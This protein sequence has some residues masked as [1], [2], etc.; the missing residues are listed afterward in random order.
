MKFL[1]SCRGNLTIKISIFLRM[2]GYIMRGNFIMM[3]NVEK[4]CCC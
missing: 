2:F 3:I 1:G 4:G